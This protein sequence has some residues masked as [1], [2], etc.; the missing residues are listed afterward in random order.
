MFASPA[1]AIRDRAHPSPVQCIKVNPTWS[2]GY[3]RKG[4]ALHGSKQYD[5]A[6]AAYEEGLKLE[7]SAALR[8]GLQ[9]V[10]EAKCTYRAASC[11]RVQVSYAPNSR[12]R[13]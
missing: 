12:N 1:H 6:I 4:A 11:T 10:K 5:D 2:K 13:V 8:K 9:E 7:D 3:A